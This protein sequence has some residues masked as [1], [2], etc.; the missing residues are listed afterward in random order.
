MLLYHSGLTLPGGFVGVD[1]FFV[2]SGYLITSQILERIGRNS[3]SLAEFWARRIRRLLPALFVCIVATWFAGWALLLP[4]DFAQLGS[5]MVWHSLLLSNAFFWRTEGYFNPESELKPLLHTWSLSIEEQFY[6][7][8]PLALWFLVV[9]F[10]RR[11]AKG[12]NIACLGGSLVACVGL[13]AGHPSASFYLLPTRGWELLLGCLLAYP[14]RFEVRKHLRELLAVLGVALVG[15]PFFFWGAETLF[16]GAAAIAPCVGAAFIIYAGFN[17]E[18]TLVARI[19]EAPP[20]RHLGLASYS[21]YLWHWPVLAFAKYHSV[22]STTSQRLGFSSFGLLLG[23]LSHALIEKKTRESRLLA[24]RSLCFRIAGVCIALLLVAGWVTSYSRGFEQRV[25]EEA[26]IF[27]RSMK[28]DGGWTRQISLNDARSGLFSRVGDVRGTK[29]AFFVWG[30]SHAM[31]ALPGLHQVASGLGFAGEAATHDTTPPSLNFSFDGSI[32]Y[33]FKSDAVGYNQAVLDHVLASGAKKVLLAAW[34]RQ[35]MDSP[36][37]V[38]GFQALVEELS[39]SGIEVYILYQ[40]PSHRLT[41]SRVFALSR[42][43]GWKEEKDV[44]LSRPEYMRI[45]AACE[46]RLLDGVRSKVKV[47]DPFPFFYPDGALE[48]VVVYGEELL[49]RDSHH[50]SESGSQFLNPLWEEFLGQKR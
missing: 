48:P 20:L 16:P 37:F 44:L 3:F 6:L 45:R 25:P 23:L 31:A 21:I 18:R 4:E 9:R 2:I 8:Y 30:D 22:L 7:L 32:R 29:G 38:D 27:A 17:G 24:D 14:M 39:D 43:R 5:S 15:Y 50:L 11:K 47:L 33:Q 46:E 10:G 26:M 1:V 13:T 40:V 12:L 35:Y 49:Y 19:L 34:W 41:L 28:S 36:G 42:W